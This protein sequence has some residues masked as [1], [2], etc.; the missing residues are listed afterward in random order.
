MEQVSEKTNEI[1]EFD[2]LFERLIYSFESHAFLGLNTYNA[3]ALKRCDTEK[4]LDNEDFNSIKNCFNNFRSHY[5]DQ[6]RQEIR[7]FMEK[8]DL[9]EKLRFK[10]EV[11]MYTMMMEELGIRLEE[12]KE[13]DE[14]SHLDGNDESNVMKYYLSNFITEKNL[15][16]EREN[17]KMR[18]EIKMLKQRNENVFN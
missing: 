15:E 3:S 4:L 10:S 13:M 1:S 14:I 5:I 8:Y 12:L 17:E 16:L 6:V 9:K 11:Y 2:Y 18:E 7:S